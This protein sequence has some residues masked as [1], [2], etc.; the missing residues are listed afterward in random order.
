ML[1]PRFKIARLMI[2]IAVSAALLAARKSPADVL[3]SALF[4]GTVVIL[5]AAVIGAVACRRRARMAWLG[6]AVFGWTYLAATFGPWPWLN[7][8]GLRPPPLL[9]SKLIE[10]CQIRYPFTFAEGHLVF[11]TSHPN[12]Q[13][14][15]ASDLSYGISPT[16]PGGNFPSVIFCFSPLKQ[17]GHSMGALLFGSLGAMLGRRFAGRG[18][19]PVAAT[20]PARGARRNDRASSLRDGRG[21][22]RGPILAEG[23]RCSPRGV[24]LL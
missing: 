9:T 23:D 3:I 17:A 4:T 5:L 21:D 2:V 18:C 11:S 6:L 20:Q 13:F 7:N 10:W 12:F 1:R 22:E 19:R 24:R 14:R 15:G 8:D 16:Y